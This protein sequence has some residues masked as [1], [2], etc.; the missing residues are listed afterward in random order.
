MAAEEILVTAVFGVGLL[1]RQFY[2]LFNVPHGIDYIGC[3]YHEH[4]MNPLWT[5]PGAQDKNTTYMSFPCWKRVCYLEP[6]LLYEYA[7]MAGTYTFS[8]CRTCK[9]HICMVLCIFSPRNL[10]QSTLVEP[11]WQNSCHWPRWHL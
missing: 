7:A 1:I 9:E 8:S 10:D 4:G 6:S 2:V 3:P 5:S 11:V